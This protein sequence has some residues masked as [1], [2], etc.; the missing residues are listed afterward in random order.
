MSI[1]VNLCHALQVAPYHVQ[2]TC[3]HENLFHYLCEQQ[4]DGLVKL[5]EVGVSPMILGVPLSCSQL[6]LQEGAKGLKCVTK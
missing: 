2:Y 1:T 6:S 5:P 4:N 3:L